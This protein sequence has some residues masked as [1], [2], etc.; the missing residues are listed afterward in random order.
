MCLKNK[1][2]NGALGLGGASSK[3]VIAMKTAVYV[4]SK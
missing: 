2:D 1:K 3:I 4:T